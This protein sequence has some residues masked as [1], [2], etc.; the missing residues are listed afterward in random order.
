MDLKCKRVSP[1]IILSKLHK[2]KR[3]ATI[4]KWI[5]DQHCWELTTFSDGK[6][7]SL[8]GPDDWSSYIRKSQKLYCTKRQCGGGS[9]LVWILVLSSGL[10]CNWIVKGNLNSD[11]YIELL[12]TTAV[13]IMKLNCGEDI[14]IQEDNSTGS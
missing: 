6:R 8:N 4:T 12:Q 10:L 11:K 3:M 1:V 7:L 14:L 9:I 13:P 2:E 5:E